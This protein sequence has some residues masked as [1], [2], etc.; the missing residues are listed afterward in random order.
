[1]VGTVNPVTDPVVAT[2]AGRLRGVPLPG[3]PGGAAFLGIP[4]AAPPFGDRRFQAPAPAAPWDG[5]RAA[6]AY[7][8]TVPKN[9]Y[10]PPFD[11]FLP[12]PAIDGPECLNLNVWTPDPGGAGLPVYVWVHGG[13]FA[14]GSG[15]VPVYDGS[16][17]ARDGVVCVTLNYRLGVDGFAHLDGAP[18]NRGLLDQV[19][20][21]E[22]VAEHIAAF[23]GDPAKVT[24]GG[25]SAG[26]MSVCSLLSMPRAAGLFRAVVA[27]SGAGHHALAASTARKVAALLGDTLGV[28]P[29]ADAVGGVPAARLLGAQAAVSAAVAADADPARWDELAVDAMPFEPEI[30][31]SV[32]P[33]LPVE[34]L[35]TADPAVRLLIGTNTDEQRLFLVP[36]GVAESAPEPMLEAVAVG[37]YGL[38]PGALAAYRAARPGASTGDVLCAVMTDWFFRVPAVRAAEAR[39]AG[40]SWMYE[41][42]WKSPIMDG[43]LGACHGVEIP[44]AFDTLGREGGAWMAGEEPPADLATAMHAAWVRFVTDGDPG[45]PAYDLTRRPTMVFDAEPALGGKGAAIVDDPRGDER[46]LWDGRR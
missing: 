1:M 6:T 15:A 17:F 28:A 27:E 5:V 14:N 38:D 35:G 39:P 23:G 24:I 25:E 34:R 3:V 45:W 8:P 16:A 36:T 19:A 29:T 22:W 42:A 32:L 41:F 18:A 11:R 37:R 31:G 40:R 46:R 4:Y 7:G 21:L 20:A 10:P 30:D 12:E 9:P 13:A 2:P 44:F 26:A 33:A 43:A